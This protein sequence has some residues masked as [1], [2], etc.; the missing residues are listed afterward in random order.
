MTTPEKAE[1]HAHRHDAEGICRC[2]HDAWY[3][4]S[5]SGDSSVHFVADGGYWIAEDPSRPGCHHIGPSSEA[6]LAGLT[7]AREHYDEVRASSPERQS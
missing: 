4:P 6:A 7:E 3:R 2:G 5:R 1:E